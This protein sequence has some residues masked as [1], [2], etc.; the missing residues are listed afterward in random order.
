MLARCESV[1]LIGIDAVP[2][3]VE[4]DSRG[5]IP[6][7]LLVG[8]PDAAVK[9]AQDRIF[10][11]LRNSGLEWPRGRVTISLAPSDLRKQG[12]HYDLPI[13]L[14][15]L[16]ASEQLPARLLE[17]F[18]VLGEL[19]LDGSLRAVPGVLSAAMG[20][21]ASGKSGL[22]VPLANGPEAAV[23]AGLKVFAVDSLA[24][25]VDFLNG[26]LAVDPVPH[27]TSGLSLEAPEYEVDFADVKGQ[28]HVK[29]AL[30][31]AAAGA[32]NVLLVGPP[33][34]GKTML[35]RRLATILP[36]LTS[37]E[38]LETSRIYSVAGM[39]PA[40][41]SLVATRPFRSPHHT[42]SNAGLVGGGGVPRPGEVSLAHNGVLFL[43]ELLEFKREVLDVMRQ[44]LED[45]HVTISRASGSLSYP[46]RFMLVAAMNPSPS[47]DFLDPYKATR[48]QMQAQER[49][50]ARLSGPLL[51]RID[52]HIE[53]PPLSKQELLDRPRGEASAAIRLR[54]A[55]A[56]ERQQRRFK[57]T[58]VHHNA[59]MSS[60]HLR[61]HCKLGPDA[62][63]LLQTAIDQFGL[64]ARAYDRI[65][66]LSR[67][68]ADLDGQD[69]IAVPH[70]AE[71]I[72]YRSLDRK[73]WRG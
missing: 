29:R 26:R 20:A 62:G 37:D 16:A 49:Y 18:A 15:I 11:A 52:M 17:D 4:V 55:M 13:A 38:A 28:D 36:P 58:K 51:D 44:P 7:V 45:G 27:H 23:V 64:S 22:L 43:D 1:A 50:L 25:A 63:A 47:G 6:K 73:L 68:I 14:A 34:A 69:E 31:V 39:I 2:V 67:T 5:G 53:V 32:H 35:A 70:V 33:G 57:G 60:R 41:Q 10:V 48:S 46:S 54:V 3:V 61:Q 65:L 72:Q 59:A 9:E 24:A 12:S 40:G 21:R 19:S 71:A 30:E 42:V 56:R 8:L 66:K